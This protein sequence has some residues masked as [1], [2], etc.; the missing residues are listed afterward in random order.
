MV[1]ILFLPAIPVTIGQMYSLLHILWGMKT[2]AIFD[3]WT[4][5]H[6]LSGVSVGH[7]VRKRN[8]R[9]FCKI[10]GADHQHH[11]WY[12]SLTG[13][14]FV[15]YAWETVEHYL[16]AGLMG[17]AVTYWFQGVEFW[18]NRLIADPLMLVIGYAIDKRWPSLVLPARFVSLA[19][20]CVHIFVFPH[21]MYLQTFF[22]I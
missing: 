13:V 4:I 14:L 3:V 15:A 18:P 6:V 5:E 1:A 21:S 20:L 19:W 16:E 8:H 2:Q 12:F 9:A 17:P 7:A 10:L 11:S 22:G